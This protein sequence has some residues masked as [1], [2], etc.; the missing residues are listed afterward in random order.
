M[1]GV[2]VKADMADLRRLKQRL[3]EESRQDMD[4]L[5]ERIARLEA[6]VAMLREAVK[7]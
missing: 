6:E 7:R 1:G 5:L 2:I 4:V 3:R